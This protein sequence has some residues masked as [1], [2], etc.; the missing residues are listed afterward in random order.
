MR[1]LSLRAILSAL[2]AVVFVIAA[3]PG[4]AMAASAK[5]AMSCCADTA[6][7]DHAKLPKD[8]DA[9][10]KNMALCAGMT[11]C[12]GMSVVASDMP[13]LR[14]AAVGASVP[15]VPQILLGLTLQPDN[16][17]PRA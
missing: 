9:P 7:C 5:H 8:K 14:S 16:P 1:K 15:S 10:C 13:L 6:S 3:E 4:V 12:F 17:P 2:L 11:S